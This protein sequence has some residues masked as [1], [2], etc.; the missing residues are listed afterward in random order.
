[1]SMAMGMMLSVSRYA[2]ERKG[3]ELRPIDDDDELPEDLK[4][5]NPAGGF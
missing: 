2:V 4:A 5:D 1:M 3:A